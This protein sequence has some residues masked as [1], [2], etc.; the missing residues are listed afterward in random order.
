MPLP[1]DINVHNEAD[2]S[3][4]LIEYLRAVKYKPN[5][6]PVNFRKAISAGDRETVCAVFSWLLPQLHILQKRAM[7]GFYL[8]MPEVPVELRTVQV[9]FPAAVLCRSG[10][11]SIGWRAARLCGAMICDVITGTPSPL[12]RCEHR[13]C[14]CCDV[15]C[16]TSCACRTYPP[17]WRRYEQYKMSSSNSTSS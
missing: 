11:P 8:T 15:A 4:K 13:R 16:S 6:D 12:H 7:V 10:S 1:E 14:L 17:E 9:S 2:P 5:M 3:G